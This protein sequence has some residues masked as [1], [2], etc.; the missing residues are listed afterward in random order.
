MS[1]RYNPAEAEL[2]WLEYWEQKNI[3]RFNPQATGD[4]YS[5]DTPP[6][7]VSGNMHI[8]HAFSY[9][10]QDI[11]ARYKR[12]RGFNVFYP[13]GT[14]DNG[15]P[16]E[17]LVEKLKNVKGAKM[18]RAD[19]IKLCETTL[20]ELIPDFVSDWK[21]IGISCD[22]A[23]SYSTINTHSR[24]ISQWSILD[25]H[26]KGRLY[27]KDA[28][29]LWCPLC[30]TAVSQVECQDAEKPSTFN[31]I[32]FTCEGN[33]LI[34]ATTRPEL[35]PACVAVFAH[36]SDER[37]KKLIGKTA[38]T[39]LFGAEVPILA[40]ERVDPAKGTGIVMCC[41]FGDQTDIQWYL[42]YNLPLK[43]AI[44]S[45]GKMTNLAG[46]FENLS[47]ND[48]RKAILAK[49][50]DEGL[51][52]A[53]K[54]IT[55]AVKTHERCGTDIE[56]IK[57]KQWFIKYLDLKDDMIAWGNQ[58]NWYPSFMQHR[59]NNWVN[60]LQWDWLISRQ[61]FFG[62]AFPIWYCKECNEPIFATEDQLPVDPLTDKPPVDTC[63]C[64]CKHFVPE[65]D[66]LDTWATS[67]MTP[68]LAVQLLPEKHRKR[69]FPMALRP[70]AHEII[71]F[72]LFNTVVKS[73]LHY[74]VNPF[75]DVALS[76]YVTD[77]KGE[78]MSKSKGNVV[79][80]HAVINKYSADALRFWA[81]GSK[82]G[83][84]IAY[85]EKE[86]KTGDRFITKIWNAAKFV[87]TAL[88]GYTK[89]NAT[90]QLDKW[91]LSK[92]SITIT[93]A[94]TAFDNYEYA[95]ARHHIEQFFWNF[96]DNYLELVKL[97]IYEGADTAA[98]QSA[99]YA[100]DTCLWAI[101][102]LM[103]PFTSF[104]TEELYHDYYAKREKLL[105]VHHA[106]WPEA[107]QRDQHAEDAGDIAVAVLSHVRKK[108]SEAKLSMKAPV[109]EL[110]IQTDVDITAVLDDL[111]AATSAEKI[112]SGNAEEELQPNLKVTVTL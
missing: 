105:S 108:K 64:G 15:L 71:S 54:P 37:Y 112:T 60:G 49:L 86:L 12:M 69:A 35:L 104:I 27:R 95:R 10:Q 52:R 73:Q 9:T 21:R 48:S 66:V 106:R 36:P 82:L 13:W 75:T 70:Q 72:W 42:A 56:I 65:H 2:K 8:G 85:Q 83:E 14:D 50:R 46:E 59:Y 43:S 29:S 110:V 53:Q 26:K 79:E 55:H 47:V 94:T 57:S 80:P 3:F 91:V 51:L 96:C 81:G 107:T 102:R 31:D 109:K 17:R 7:T 98:K 24:R 6:P 16:T 40:D 25:L 4:I 63:A 58:L 92:L 22:F 62:V 5:I 45:T 41:T 38:K 20:K 74:G 30:A 19:F 103:A 39:P 44:S 78:K 90:E 32:V 61:R 33:E 87:N 18:Q 77:S 100:L 89:G 111:K 23:T 97:R 11:I 93:E 99:Q 28:P 68:Q 67:S 1:E 84:D 76:G 34:I 101:I 88:D